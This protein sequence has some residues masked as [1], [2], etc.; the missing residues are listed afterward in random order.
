MSNIAFFKDQL[1]QKMKDDL[2]GQR[3]IG[4]SGHSGEP[5]FISTENSF[6][7]HDVFEFEDR[8]MAHHETFNQ[9]LKC[10]VVLKT[11]FCHED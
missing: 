4:D 10:F 3:L 5:D 1:R 6:D 7:P 2:P 11:A 8:M 9:Q